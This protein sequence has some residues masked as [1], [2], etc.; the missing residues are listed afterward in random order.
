MEELISTN[1]LLKAALDNHEKHLSDQLADLDSRETSLTERIN[2]LNK[3]KEDTAN[4]NGN[5][6]AS[7]EDLI[8]INAGGKQIVA[9]RSTLIQLKDTMLEALFSGRWEKRLQRDK[10]GRIF[11]DVNSTCFQAIVD[12]LNEMTISSEDN[13]PD[14][15][16]VDDENKVSRR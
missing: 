6:D 16:T 9:K 7:P 10:N 2:K 8:E 11:L 15:P 1:S 12:Y 5:L 3:T 13:P 4:D 14:P